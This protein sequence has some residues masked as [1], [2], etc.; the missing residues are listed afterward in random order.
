MESI[1]INPIILYLFTFYILFTKI[2]VQLPKSKLLFVYVKLIVN[3]KKKVPP[4][5]LYC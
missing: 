1:Y 4:Q 5:L 3:L 2:L